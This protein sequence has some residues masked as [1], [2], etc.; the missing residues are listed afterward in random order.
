[1]NQLNPQRV[2]ISTG[3]KL[4]HGPKRRMISAL[5]RPITLSA[6][7]AKALRDHEDFARPRP[8]PQR[9]RHRP[10]HRIIH[11][12]ELGQI[13]REEVAAFAGLAPF[14]DDSG[15]YHG[16]RHIAGGRGRLRRR[17]PGCLPLE[18]PGQHLLPTPHRRRQASR[19]RTDRLL[20]EAFAYAN[21]MP[22]RYDLGKKQHRSNGSF[23]RPI[24][25]PGLSLA[26]FFLARL[27]A[28]RC[29]FKW[30]AFAIVLGPMADRLIH[31]WFVAPV[32]RVRS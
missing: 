19:S 11:I 4:R 15:D 8:C 20:Q 26:A 5:N 30:V 12:P 17:T 3:S 22:A 16:Q 25:R 18:P 21:T 27:D 13:S 24:S 6:R 14:D 31:K 2:S 28:V 1:L 7:I 9:S 10:A 23:V 32:K 29:A